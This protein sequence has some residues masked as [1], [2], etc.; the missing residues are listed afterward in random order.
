[1][2]RDYKIGIVIGL[3]VVIAGVV[4][5]LVTGDEDPPQRQPQPAAQEQPDQVVF[6]DEETNEP[7]TTD[8]PPMPV[9]VSVDDVP[10]TTDE[11]A[12]EPAGSV[13]DDREATDND[14]GTVAVAWGSEIADATSATDRGTLET[15]LPATSEGS[16]FSEPAA[17]ADDGTVVLDADA[18]S[19]L[20]EPDPEPVA[21]APA[22]T[23]TRPDETPPTTTSADSYDRM[24]PVRTSTAPAT[25]PTT[26]ASPGTYK[27]TAEDT[28]GFW[29]ISRKVYGRWKYYQLI[30]DANPQVDSRAL[31]PGTML[32]IPPKPAETSSTDRTDE[33]SQYGQVSTNAAG[34]KVYTVSDTDT[35]GLWGIAKKVYGKGHLWPRIAK[36]NPDV[37]PTKLNPGD[38]LVIPTPPAETTVSNSLGSA[39]RAAEAR[40]GQTIMDGGERYYIVA[41]G[42][43]GFWGISATVYGDGKYSYMISRANPGVD[44]DKLQPGD[45]LR[46]PPLP[47]A[48]ERRSTRPAATGGIVA[49]PVRPTGTSPEPD[50]GP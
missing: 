38:K 16:A 32:R 9:S 31:Q 24:T 45:K 41:G 25:T 40:H 15:G 20:D 12:D 29:G 28:T 43:A 30:Q 50:F 46:V 8:I 44:S 36:A 22:A 13:M 42:D 37:E 21:T 26:P 3:L 35:A 5:F 10:E 14:D 47:P 23:T 19:V 4:Y 49:E 18:E 33:R 11:V 6:T 17:P 34:R 39:V 7:T 27:V 48:S 2:P 1:M